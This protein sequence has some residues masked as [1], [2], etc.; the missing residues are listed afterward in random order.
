[1]QAEPK[2]WT[3][4]G[5]AQTHPRRLLRSCLH[6]P[7]LNSESA[8]WQALSMWGRLDLNQ[9]L[10]SADTWVKSV[11]PVGSWRTAS[12]ATP[13]LYLASSRMTRRCGAMLSAT[14]PYSRRLEGCRR[15]FFGSHRDTAGIVLLA[16]GR[17]ERPSVC[18]KEQSTHSFPTA[19]RFLGF[20]LMVFPR[21]PFPYIPFLSSS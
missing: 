4:T 5:Q 12:H 19:P 1:V 9:Q 16:R 14:V 21:T 10:G 11:S 2:E 8:T 15:L 20:P 7:F 17:L 13:C 18:G 3:G 6:R